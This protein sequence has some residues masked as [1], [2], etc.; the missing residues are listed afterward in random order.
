MQSHVE[1]VLG[2]WRRVPPAELIPLELVELRWHE[3]EEVYLM[4]LVR[5]RGTTIRGSSGVVSMTTWP[6]GKNRRYL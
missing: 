5:K 2:L 6:S 4:F 1:A 3:T